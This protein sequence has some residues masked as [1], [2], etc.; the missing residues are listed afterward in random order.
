MLLHVL[1]LEVVDAGPPPAP[2][3]YLQSEILEPAIELVVLR[4]KL[5]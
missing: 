3:T 4:L 1:G 5:P 2:P